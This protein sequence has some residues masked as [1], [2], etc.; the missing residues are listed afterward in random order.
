M[1]RR[2]TNW[3]GRS[4][5]RNC[6][7]KHII[8]G[9]VEGDTEVTRRQGTTCK[10]LLDDVK[11]MRGYWELKED[12]LDYAVWRTRLEELVISQ[13]TE[14]THDILPLCAMPVMGDCSHLTSVYIQPLIQ[15]LPCGLHCTCILLNRGSTS[16]II[17]PTC[18]T[19]VTSVTYFHMSS[20]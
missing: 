11:E 14:W 12:A 10:Q 18:F 7:L 5:R 3:I 15:L 8:D 19:D 20:V 6:L 1:K 4:L 17:N 2:K 16:D 13:T 9:K